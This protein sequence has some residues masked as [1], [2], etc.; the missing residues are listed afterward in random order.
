MINEVLIDSSVLIEYM[1]DSKTQLLTSLITNA[2]TE[3]F[4]NEIIVSE[5]LYYYIGL[6]GGRSPRTV[7]S[8]NQIAAIFNQSP[9]YLLIESFSF[10]S[11]KETLLDLVPDFMVKYNLLPND[12]IILATCKIHGI[13][14]LASHDKD[15]EEPCKAEGITLLK[16]Q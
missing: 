6:Y 2:E 16:E 11:S 4:I 1:K 12:A 13:T 7:Q 14:Q 8:A 3:C 10:L 5:F 9:D 15:F